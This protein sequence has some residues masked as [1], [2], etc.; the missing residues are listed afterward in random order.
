MPRMAPLLKHLRLGDPTSTPVPQA[1]ET[2]EEIEHRFGA[3]AYTEE[4]QER[5]AEEYA[6]DDARN[7]ATG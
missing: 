3:T 7:R 1:E 4:D 5:D 6:D 2:K